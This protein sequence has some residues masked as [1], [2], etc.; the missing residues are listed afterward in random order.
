[1]TILAGR[2]APTLVGASP[3]RSASSSDLHDAD[4]IVVGAGLGGLTAAA[5]LARA[6]RRVVVFDR[7]QSPG[8]NASTYR[9]GP[10]E[11]DIGLHYVGECQPGG[12][13]RSVLEPLDLGLEFLQLDPKGH[14]T[15]HLPGAAIRLPADGPR[16]RD[17]IHAAFPAERKAID[18][19]FS[20]VERVADGL[21]EI[22]R[23]GISARPTRALA[24]APR[25]LPHAR[26][27]LADLLDDIGASPALRA[28]L[29][30]YHPYYALPPS[31]TPLLLHAGV[32][33]HFRNGAFYPAGG[34][35][36]IARRLVGVVEACGGVVQLQSRVTHIC[37]V[38]GGARRRVT[39]VTVD[40]PSS[41]EAHQLHGFVSAPV[42]I[43]NADI[44]RTFTEFLDPPSARHTRRAARWEPALPLALVSLGITGDL[45]AE[46]FPNTNHIVVGDLDIEAEYRQLGAG[47]LSEHPTTLLCSTTTKNPNDD[48]IAP[49]GHSNLQLM[50]VAPSPGPFW[51][52]GHSEGSYRREDTYRLAKEQ[53]RERM[54]AS[55]Q[56]VVPDLAQRIVFSEDASPLTHTRFLGST[57]G[58]P[59][60]LASTPS[61]F[62]WRRPSP[63][64]SVSGLFLTG[65]STS[66]G[67]GTMSVVCSGFLTASLVL[68]APAN[69]L[70]AR[71]IT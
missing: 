47:Q 17:A 43:S 64:T 10:W 29:C 23:A 1:M 7:Y 18:A 50:A 58:S 27:T 71:A 8:G 24:A 53:L 33:L 12:I 39:G 21:N 22:L 13:L 44:T 2:S 63:V 68:R 49:A 5:Y 9:R 52:S 4:V 59:Y 16:H 41:R 30:A 66:F 48:S 65:A 20:I 45:N 35:G 11:F 6:G 70:L 56:R 61:Q 42:V 37:H 3:L 55:A 51:R 38:A 14:D 25:V 31:R 40:V 36:E 19:Y 32:A 62:M 34:A 46:G 15:V 54:I 26:R 57:G 28:A 69:R 60:G 67:H